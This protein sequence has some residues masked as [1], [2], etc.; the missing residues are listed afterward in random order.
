M[1]SDWP[2]IE[3]RGGHQF[4]ATTMGHGSLVA[5]ALLHASRSKRVLFAKICQ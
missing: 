3:I 4:V 5:R 2:L 1:C